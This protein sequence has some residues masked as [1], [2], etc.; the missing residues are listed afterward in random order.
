MLDRFHPTVA[1]WF[2]DRLGDPSPPQVAGWPH[3]AGGE[4][5]LIAAP[6]GSGKTLAAFLHA[7]DDLLRLG[8]ALGDD[9]HVVYVSPLRALANDVQKN[10][11]QPLAE[12]RARNPSLPDVRVAVRSGDTPQKDRQAMLRKPPHILVT[13]PES[14]YILTT[15]ERGRA[16]LGKARTLIVDEIHALAGSKRGSHF[17]LTC[18]RF[19]HLVR[20]QGGQLQRI[21]LSATQKPIEQTAGLLAGRGRDCRI[22]DVGHRR[23]LDLAVVVP[24]APLDTICS[25]ETWTEV[26]ARICALIEQHRTTL[27]FTN[28]RKMAERVA[29]RLRETLGKEAVTSHHGSLA[30]ERRL[31]AEQRLK[32]GELRA[33]VATSSLELGID[34]GDVELVVQ[35][36]P[37]P[38]IAAFLQRV[39]RAGHTLGATPKG[40]LFP[41]TRDELVAAA[42]TVH[43]VRAGELDRT[44][45]PQN[46]LD[47]LAQQIV[48]AGATATWAEDELFEL[49]TTAWPF[50]TLSRERFDAVLAMHADGRT[51]LLH[52]DS[53]HGT[54]RGTRR[55]RLTAVTCGGAIPDVADWQVVLDDDDTPVGTVHED[56]AIESSIGDVFQLGTTSWQ[57]RRISNGT[58]RVADAH[59]VPPSLPFWIAEGP[60]R[61]DELARAVSRVRQRGVD[62]G[63]LREACGLGDDAA[64]QLAEYLQQGRD[65][66][67]AT[68]SHD[69]LVLERFFDETGGQ[70][71][72]LHAPFGSRI[73]RAFGLALRKRFCVG[74]GFELQAAANEEALLI[75]LGP[76][77]SFPLTDVWQFLNP[78]T[79][80]DVLIQAM[81]PAPLF[82]ARWRWNV[83]RSLLVERFRSGGKVPAP[84]L[85]FRADDALATAFPAAQ[86]CPETLPGGPID[87]PLDHPMVDQTVHDS[88]YEAMDFDGLHALLVRIQNGGVQLLECERSEPSPFAAS[89]LNAMPYAFLDDAPLE[90]RRT[91]AVVTAQRGGAARTRDESDSE[92]DPD[93]LQQVREECWP[94]PRDAAELH[95]AL[96]WMGWL[97]RSEVG[98]DWRP[99][100]D[101]LLADGRAL[102]DGE[103][104]FAPEADR[105]PLAAWRGRLEAVIPVWDDQLDDDD[106][107]SLRALE[108]EGTAMRARCQGRELWAHRRLLARVRRAMVERLRRAV[109]PVSKADYE[110]FVPIWQ[111][112]TPTTRRTGPLGLSETLSQLGCLACPTERWEDE[113]LPNHLDRYHREWLDQVTLSGELVWLRLWGPWRGPLSKLPLSIVPRSELHLWLQL[114]LDR[115][116]VDD[117]GGDARG[118]YDLLQERGA[119]FPTDLQAHAKLLPSHFEDALGELVGA[120]LVTCD[121]F[122]AM[123]QLAIAPSKRRFPLF[124]VGRWSLLPVPAADTRAS[125]EAIEMVAGALLRRFG[126]LSHALLLDHKVPIPW[127]LLLRTLRQFELRG[128][129]RGGRFVSGW[130]GE[131]YALPDAVAELRR[132]ARADANAKSAG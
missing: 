129:V 42:A 33:L 43:A 102:P 100:L 128:D 59:G 111:K 20:E 2:R 15:T 107:E 109:R 3:I 122:A 125:D 123:R 46:A 73:N 90:E 94:E 131:Q 65:A 86:A 16:M 56:F 57:V 23:E 51:A 115:A 120:G 6:T 117:L 70:Q 26:F 19:D 8:D 118:L 35:I 121:S 48:A 72:I 99:W 11:Q 58:L 75:S 101:E 9:L 112:A 27:V 7:L 66:L 103:R 116:D 119:L 31:D 71:L 52:R 106:R 55:A 47:I 39:G 62:V 24:G 63:W 18:E 4:H 64:E 92:L 130:A 32:R 40:R 37:T 105:A 44:I 132:V 78:K 28:T 85:R 50:R 98:D 29:A 83:T 113:V 95:E 97:E 17:A 87:V 21:G 127:R 53:V 74:F 36:G 34:V 49:V 54:V 84:L 88:L 38:T 68:P 93:A 61:S 5:T 69:T 80:K 89:I 45:Q 14:L 25:G 124:A 13:T 77:H 79:V 82:Q 96:G 104:L 110:A 114:P 67:G 76:M 12:L 22:V 81:L 60:S 10:L 30:K 126:V 91:Q 1:T 41:L 108:A